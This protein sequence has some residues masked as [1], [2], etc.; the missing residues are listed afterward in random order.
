MIFHILL[1]TPRENFFSVSSDYTGFS[2]IKIHDVSAAELVFWNNRLIKT[3]INE[4][5]AGNKKRQSLV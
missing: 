5:S 2:R 3:G 1:K 4:Y